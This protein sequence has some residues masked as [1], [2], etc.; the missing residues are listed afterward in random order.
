MPASRRGEGR[1]REPGTG[2]EAPAGLG[3]RRRLPE[4]LSGACSGER[5]QGWA[6]LAQAP[7]P[8][9]GPPSSS[10]PAP[11]AR[12]APAAALPIPPGAVAPPPRRSH[13]RRRPPA[14]RSA[15]PRRAPPTHIPRPSLPGNHPAVPSRGAVS[16]LPSPTP[17]G[18]PQERPAELRPRWP[19]A[20]RLG[21]SH[22]PRPG[23]GM[24]PLPTPPFLGSV[25][26]EGGE[27]E[28]PQGT[29]KEQVPT[30]SGPAQ[31]Q[32]C[33]WGKGAGFTCPTRPPS[34]PDPL[35]TPVFASL[36]HPLGLWYSTPQPPLLQSLTG[37][38]LSASPFLSLLPPS[39]YSPQRYWSPGS[40]ALVPWAPCSRPSSPSQ[41]GS[42]SGP[43]SSGPGGVE[44]SD[45]WQE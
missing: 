19:A 18:F 7:P 20:A 2:V 5:S 15:R 21:A 28:Q 36:R 3:C 37:L 43:A 44:G 1:R 40:Q 30:G 4:Q 10:L 33:G 34:P 8:S 39:S 23:E 14:Q 35:F 42:P 16:Q 25:P 26:R 38:H 27:G 11:P 9:P 41:G 45:Q 17:P 32:E 22:T 6:A 31:Q 13:A 29:G 24:T 12:R